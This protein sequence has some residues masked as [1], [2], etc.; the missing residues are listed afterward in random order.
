[1]HITAVSNYESF[2]VNSFGG[3]GYYMCRALAKYA[4]SLEYVAP[5]GAPRL[6]KP[7]FDIKKA[8]YEKKIHRYYS[9]ERDHL[10]MKNYARQIERSLKR[11]KT[12]VVFSPTSPGSQPVAYLN[13]K[14]PIV[15][16]TDTTFAGFID[17]HPYFRKDYMSKETIRDGVENERKALGRSSLII[18]KTHWAA[19]F[20][21]S[22]YN[23]DPEKVKVVPGGPSFPFFYSQAIDVKHNIENRPKDKCHIL[24]Q[25]GN[26]EFKGGQTVKELTVL[27]NESGL[28][29]VLTV[30]GCEPDLS[31]IPEQ[32]YNIVGYLDKSKPNEMREMAR[33]IS[34][35]HFLILPTIAEAM[36]ISFLEANLFGVPSIATKVGGITS[37]VKDGINGKTFEPNESARMYARFI[38][39]LF[40]N[41]T[42]YE[43]LAY[44]SY[45]E[46]LNR[47][48]WDVSAQRVIGYMHQIN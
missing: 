7:F 1:M 15:I 12:D 43:K 30:I 20:A 16:W 6:F 9:V 4:D 33:I 24:F 10:L 44:S 36:G 41:Y 39:N 3:R 19:N 37:I 32:Y 48:N 45:N 25:A 31:D 5:I 26:W 13:T 22:Y 46:Y 38:Q 21:I 8:V 28:P 2:N 23:L 47:L 34:E 17:F 14:K 11:I 40:H 29:T 18:Y 27:L 42:D 35:S